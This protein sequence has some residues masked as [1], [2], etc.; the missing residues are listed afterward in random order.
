MGL[1]SGDAFPGPRLVLC[2]LGSLMGSRLL[3]IGIL[4]YVG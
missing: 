2:R 4:L 3:G 1:V